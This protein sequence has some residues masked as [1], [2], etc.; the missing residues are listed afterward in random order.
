[1]QTSAQMR[2]LIEGFEGCRLDP[3][4]DT[5]GVWTIGY[6]HTGDDVYGGCGSIDQAT[7][8]QML[9]DDLSDFE[10]AVNSLC[11]KCTQQQFDAL[12]SFSYNLGS[13]A[14][15]GSTLRRMHNAGNYTGAA[16]EFGKWNH[17]GGRVLAGLTR[18]RA[19][20]AAVYAHGNYGSA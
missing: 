10:D 17:A 3:Y 19:A 2:K 16:G 20:E 8:D 9:A 1:M 4:Q 13:G 15:R 11:P 14:L 6:G 5:V 12:V 7:A 18:R